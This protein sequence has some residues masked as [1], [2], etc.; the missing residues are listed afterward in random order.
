[1]NDCIQQRKLDSLLLY[2]FTTYQ[3]IIFVQNINNSAKVGYWLQ[4]S[5]FNK[6]T[7]QWWQYPS[8][9]SNC[10]Q[11]T[12]PLP[13]S[14]VL[15]SWMLNVVGS[16]SFST[17]QCIKGPMDFEYLVQVTHSWS[18]GCIWNLLTCQ[19]FILQHS[20]LQLAC[21]QLCRSQEWQISDDSLW[22][23]SAS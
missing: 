18:P 12:E 23:L 19:R 13:V 9:W 14:R 15:C 6:R 7:P 10:E 8:H 4:R 21:W 22:K 2:T 5:I 11:D 17:G 3:Y 20:D 16:K 1:M